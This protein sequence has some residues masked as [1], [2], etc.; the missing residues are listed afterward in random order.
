MY[1]VQMCMMHFSLVEYPIP[2][3]ESFKEFDLDGTI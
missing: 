1:Y 3:S 2:Q